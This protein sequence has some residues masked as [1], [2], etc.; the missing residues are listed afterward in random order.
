MK[1]L[2]EIRLSKPKMVM[3]DVYGISGCLIHYVFPFYR[4]KTVDTIFELFRRRGIPY[5]FVSD[6]MPITIR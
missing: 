3:N 5:G 1:E 6:T 4:L 2:L